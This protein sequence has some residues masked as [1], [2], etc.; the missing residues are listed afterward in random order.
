MSKVELNAHIKPTPTI[1]KAQV[2][3]IIIEKNVF[4]VGKPME[5]VQSCLHGGY[6]HKEVCTCGSM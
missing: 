6:Y 2:G 5:K 4:E 1:N 3:R